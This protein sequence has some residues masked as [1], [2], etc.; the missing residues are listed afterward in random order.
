MGGVGWLRAFA[1]AAA[2]AGAFAAHGQTPAD[3]ERAARE[4]ERIQREQQELIRRQRQ[5]QDAGRRPAEIRVAPAPKPAPVTPGGPCRE[6]REI[7]LSGAANLDARRRERLLAPYTGRC[8]TLEDI[9]QLLAAITNDY[10]ERGF[11]TTRAYVP[12]QDLSGGRLEILVVEGVVERI[13]VDDGGADSVSVGTAFPGVEGRILNLRDLEQGL[14]QIN[15]LGSNNATLDIEP[16]SEA[17]ASVVVIRNHPGNRYFASLGAD[18][19]GS[20]STGRDQAGA[21]VG[22]NNLLG[23]ND[24][25]S[26][27]DRR[28]VPQDEAGKL[29]AAQTFTASVPYGYSTFTFSVSRSR[30]VSSVTGGAGTFKT[31]GSSKNTS[32]KVDHVAYRDRANRLSLSAAVT[33][34]QARNY[35]LES[36][37]AASSRNLAVLD[38]DANLTTGFAGGVL[39][40]DGGY[41][42]GLKNFGALDDPAGLPRGVPRAQFE[43]LKYGFTW[44][45]PFRAAGLDASFST[46]LVGQYADDALYGSEQIAA[47]GFYTVRGYRNLSIAGDRGYYVRNDLAV[48]VPFEAAGTTV[49]ARPY[50]ALDFGR[51]SPRFGNPGG[52]IS[53]WALGASFAVGAHV[54][55]DIAMTR[56]LDKPESLEGLPDGPLTFLRLS[57]SF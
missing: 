19:S 24:F 37:I 31:T 36:L 11:V 5:E 17:G 23:L 35:I 1:A 4:A 43:K 9:N 29:S 6:V 50:V 3:L 10:V 52:T 39:V 28:S 13:R 51:I 55:A 18:S 7:R 41:A 25:L 8:L 49:L 38:L 16:G 44:S 15:R 2:I 34:K 26:F 33:A 42:R 30:Y 48:R 57:L 46:A 32:F 21:T 12:P 22:A 20:D 14:D 47:G 40:L 45:R 56:P 53:G 54:S 27:S